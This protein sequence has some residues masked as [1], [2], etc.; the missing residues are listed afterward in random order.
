M[1]EV[2]DW[3]RLWLDAWPIGRLAPGHLETLLPLL[4]PDAQLI[5]AELHWRPPVAERSARIQAAALALRDR[6][7]IRGWRGE[8]YACEAPVPEPC[9]ERGA[10]LFRLERA[11][12]RYFGLM[13]RAVHIN[14]WWPDGRMLCGRR[15]LSKATDPGK[16]DNLAA[17]GLGAGESLLDCARRELWEEAGVPLVLS[18]DLRDAGALRSRRAIAGEGLHDEVLHLYDLSLPADFMPRNR[19]GEVQEFLFLGPQQLRERL[20]AGEFSPDAAQVVLRALNS[21]V[22]P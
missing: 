14:G 22:R 3:P 10:E 15:A 6:G 11:A 17:G 18:Q 8:A 7:L 1:P 9:R 16:L 12:F 4:A 2:Q 5:D 13:S 21:P 20:A 19:D